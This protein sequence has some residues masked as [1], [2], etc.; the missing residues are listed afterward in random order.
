MPRETPRLLRFIVN[1]L[2]PVQVDVRADEIGAER[3][4]RWMVREAAQPRGPGHQMWRKG[5]RSTFE[6]HEA[7]VGLHLQKRLDLRLERVQL[8]EDLRQLRMVDDVPD[9]HVSV[10]IEL[11]G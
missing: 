10:C 3:Y 2:V 6:N 11:L 4:E 5:D 7:S 9:H 8:L 1:R